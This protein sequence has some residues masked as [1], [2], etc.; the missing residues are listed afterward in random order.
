MSSTVTTPVKLGRL[1]KSD[2]RRQNKRTTYNA[3]KFSKI[4]LRNLNISDINVH[5]IQEITTKSCHVHCRTVHKVCSEA[6]N[7][8]LD[9]QIFA[10]PR[11]GHKRKHDVT[12]A[13]DFNKDVLYQTVYKFCK[14]GEYP[15][16]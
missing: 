7:F 3:Y 2:I 8:S 15:T 9:N 5:K 12:N 13:N 10:F 14:K 6:F 4:F 1:G 16:E 11:K